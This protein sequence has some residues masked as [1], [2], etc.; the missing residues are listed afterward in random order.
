MSFLAV[1][2]LLAAAAAAD[3]ADARNAAWREDLRALATELPKRHKNLFFKLHRE[4]FLREVNALEEAIPRLKDYEVKAGMIRLVARVGDG[5]TTVGWSHED[6][7]L[8]PL[9]IHSFRE[10]YFVL[11]TGHDNQ[12]ALGARLVKVGDTDIDEAI[13]RIKRFIACENPSCYL[14][15]LPEYLMVP[16]FYAS[17]GLIPDPTKGSFVFENGEGKRFTQ[18]LKAIPS[19]G[20]IAWARLTP[21]TGEREQ[22]LHRNKRESNYWYEY[23]PGSKTLYFAYNRC[24]DMDRDAPPLKEFTKEMMAFAD[25]HEVE[26]FVIDLRRNGGGNE[27]L[28]KPFIADLKKDGKLNRRGHLFVVVGRNTFSSAAQNAMELEEKTQASTVGEP[29]G[30]KPNHYGEVKTFPLPHWGIDVYYSTTFWKRVDGDPEALVPAVS[31]PPSAAA[32]L[33]GRDPVMEAILSWKEEAAK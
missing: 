21:P 20:E 25:T 6:F 28:L 1:A 33:A 30:Q 11:A 24:R 9:Q 32:T 7:S 8:F 29:T 10:G 31:A 15:R 26:R 4:E 12:E 17:E 13:T 3:P 22:A 16:E 14:A 27:G 23:V 18:E 5:H 19:G 2:A